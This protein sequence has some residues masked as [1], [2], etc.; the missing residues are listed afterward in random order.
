VLL[1]QAPE[2]VPRGLRIPAWLELLLVIL[3]A[4]ALLYVYIR[5][6]AIEALRT[7]I[8]S[9]HGELRIQQAKVER[10]QKEVDQLTRHNERYEE[11]LDKMTRRY[12]RA[13]GELEEKKE[14]GRSGESPNPR[15][16]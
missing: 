8:E 16:R 1:L 5:S 9:L 2:L 13:V 11:D 15:K 6:R 12:L 4:S 14:L 3:A 10:L 7:E